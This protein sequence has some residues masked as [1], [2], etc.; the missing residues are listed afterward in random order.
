VMDRPCC[1]GSARASKARILHWAQVSSRAALPGLGESPEGPSTPAGPR[2]VSAEYQCLR[3][4]RTEPSEHVGEE[5]LTPESLGQTDLPGEGQIPTANEFAA[6]FPYGTRFEEQPIQA[7]ALAEFPEHP[8]LP[9]FP[10]GK[11]FRALADQFSLM[12]DATR[13]SILWVLMRQE[14]NVTELCK[15]LDNQSQPAV[16]H[17]LA[18]LRNSGLV[19]TRR[20]G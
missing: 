7:R 8:C 16:S 14:A 9:D 19:E 11:R 13:L 10:G 3:D 6:R 2:I 15:Y 18:L 1:L 20:D 12:S 5:S 17:H 4:L